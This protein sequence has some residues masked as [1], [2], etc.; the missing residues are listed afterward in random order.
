[1]SGG[2]AARQ[3]PLV[4]VVD[5]VPD[6]LE[7]CSQL[8]QFRGFD[9][10]TA[11]DGVEAMERTHELLPDVVLMDI[12]LP[13]MDGLEATRRLK[14]DPRTSAIPIL[15]VTAHALDSA[16]L[17]ALAAGCSDV[18]TKPFGAREIEEAIRRQLPAPQADDDMEPG[19]R[20][21]TT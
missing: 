7:V 13:R 2:A 9:V 15:A 21:G 5:D 12:S 6:G 14:K 1:M 4:L 20:G 10:A 16:R 11:T 3:R 18:V 17:E 19:D 8:L